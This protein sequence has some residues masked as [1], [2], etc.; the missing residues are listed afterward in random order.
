MR[1]YVFLFLFILLQQL[2]KF[3]RTNESVAWLDWRFRHNLMK[4]DDGKGDIFYVIPPGQDY[5]DVH[6][7]AREDEEE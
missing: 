7:Y 6:V 2:P 4:I 1:P 3:Y 5:S